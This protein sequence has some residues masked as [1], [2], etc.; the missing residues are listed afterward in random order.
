M[1]WTRLAFFSASLHAE[2]QKPCLTMEQTWKHYKSSPICPLGW[3][4]GECKFLNIVYMSLSPWHSTKPLPAA[5]QRRLM[6]EHMNFPLHTLYFL[7]LNSTLVLPV[8]VS[9]PH[10]KR[11]GLHRSLQ[12]HSVPSLS[13]NRDA[14][15]LQCPALQYCHPQ[16]HLFLLSQIQGMKN[17]QGDAFEYLSDSQVHS[18]SAISLSISLS[19]T[20]LKSRCRKVV[21]VIL[22]LRLKKIPNPKNNSFSS[23]F[24]MKHSVQWT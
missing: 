24:L 9:L 10:T 16:N 3:V 11:T 18:N 19:F 14:F 12:E 23:S 17:H 22:G 2:A 8:S 1:C 5:L 7:V 20:V 4:F 15:D 13:N 6:L 21:S